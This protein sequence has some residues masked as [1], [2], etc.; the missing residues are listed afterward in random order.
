MQVPPIELQPDHATAYGNIGMA[1]MNKLL[2]EEAIP[3]C[4]KQIELDP[5]DTATPSYNLACCYALTDDK[6]KAFEWLRKA[7]EAGFRNTDHMAQDAAMNSLREDARYAE[8]VALMKGERE[9]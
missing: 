5:V 8:I 9:R 1:L 6:E 3:Y 7:A 4:E 2:F